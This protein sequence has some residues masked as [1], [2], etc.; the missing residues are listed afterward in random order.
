MTARWSSRSYTVNDGDG[1]DDYTVTTQSAA[2]TITPASL[3][4]TPASD[5][6][7]YDGTTASSLT[8]TY[9]GL[10]TVGG[11][12]LTGLAQ[13]FSSKNVLGANDSTLVVTSYTVND[14][15]GGNDYAVTTQS[16]AGT[17]TPAP[18]TITATT[19]TKVYDGTTSAIPTPTFTGL[20][21]V[22]GDTITGLTEAFSSKNVLGAGDSTL[23]VATYTVNDGDGGNDYAVTTQ[24]AAGTISPAPLTITATTDSKV[25]NGT[26]LSAATPTSTGLI[27]VGGDT[28]TSLAEAFSSK[29]VRGT[30][31]STLNVTSYTIND[32]DGGN[33]YTVTT[34]SAGGTITPASLT[35]IA[36][37]DSRV[38]D[39]TTS[40][41]ITPTYTGL[42]TVGGDTI[43]G[44]AEAFSSKNVLGPGESTLNVTSYTVNDGDGGN[45]YTVTT[46]H[47][48]GSI[49]PAPL[50]I[51]AASDSRV[52]DGTIS[53]TL[54]PTVTGLM[55]VGGDT[56]TGL[57][58]A[59]GSK[60]VLG[61]GDSTLIVT[62][63]TV[64]DGNGGNDYTVTTPSAGGTITP[65]P[66]DDHRDDR[67]EGLRRND[68]VDRDPDCHRFDHRG[69]RYHHRSGRSVQLE[70]CA[71]G[72]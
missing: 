7:G 52:Y 23:I 41:T 37:S 65:A 62:S 31:D 61:A 43:T 72:W 10:I 9:S 3:T 2:G 39:G 66:L 42:I 54:V 47:A 14:G 20:I 45:D 19:A 17:I 24:S 56:V 16:A 63:Y 50:T 64:N 51:T 48:T 36:A 4:I 55:T 18:L 71:G 34:Q 33:D 35:I 40:A 60:N 29:N 5:S 21:T 11:D 22:S 26:T 59:F 1:G 68:R 46:R 30:G 25:Y 67:L 57:A 44:L 12:T 27:T 53:S 15:D 70:E 8:P 38:Y 6:K 58:Q 32:G 69:R 49:L 13:A 28:I